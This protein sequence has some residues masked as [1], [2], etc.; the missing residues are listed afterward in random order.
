MIR[1]N[2]CM[3]KSLSMLK[4]TS[5]YQLGKI[6]IRKLPIQPSALYFDSKNINKD[7]NVVWYAGA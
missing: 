5:K 7:L 6:T 4:E 3:I 1:R 2:N